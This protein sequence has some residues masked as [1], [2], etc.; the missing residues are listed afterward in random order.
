VAELDISVTITNGSD[1]LADVVLNRAQGFVIVS[2]VRGVRTPDVSAAEGEWSDGDVPTKLRFPRMHGQV[3][4]RATRGSYADARAALATVRAA[5]EQITFDVVVT[6]EDDTETWHCTA[7]TSAEGSVDGE[8]DQTDAMH[9]RQ[10]LYITDI[11]Y[12]T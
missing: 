7:A 8:I 1:D 10:T 4:V 6:V 2:I 3:T 12:L 11:P 9:Q 5:V